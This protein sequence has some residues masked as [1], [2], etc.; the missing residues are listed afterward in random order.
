MTVLKRQSDK[1]EVLSKVPLFAGLSK[2]ELT[3]MARRVGETEFVPGEHILLEGE[4]AHECFV[5]LDGRAT[6]R[7]NGEKI[8]EVAKGDVI[9]EMSLV[10]DLRRSAGVRAD[11]FV[12]ALR[13]GRSDFIAIMDEYPRVAAKVLK[14]VADRLVANTS[15]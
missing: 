13:I 5:L 11:T 7:R 6:V 15:G 9:G 3:G 4:G 12:S 2:R 10:T 14:T 8:A 1:I